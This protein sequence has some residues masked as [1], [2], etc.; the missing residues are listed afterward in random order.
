MWPCCWPAARAAVWVVLTKNVAKPAVPFGGKYRIIDFPAVQLR[1]LRHRHGG[2][3][4]PVSAAGAERL[5][6]QRRSRGTWTCPTAACTSCRPMQTGK[7]GRMVQGHGQRHLSE[8]RLS[9]TQYDPDYVAH[10][11][12]RPYLQ[13]GLRRR[14][15]ASTISKRRRLHHRRARGAAGGGQPAS[16]S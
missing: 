7:N 3:P 16:A 2:H 4:D 11:L 5:H 6:R 1:Q 8:H 9:S 12:R 14:C 15:C 10:P 13:D